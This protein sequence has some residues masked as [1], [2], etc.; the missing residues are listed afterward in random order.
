M[1]DF[2]RAATFLI[3]DLASTICFLVLF[4][5]THNTPVSVAGGAA[6]GLIQIAV[7]LIRSRPVHTMEWL[8][9]FLVAA[10]GTASIL[11][12]DPRFLLFKPSVVYAVVG[13]VMLK[14]GW[15]VRYLPAIVRSV[16][17]DVAVLAGYAFA[18][19]MFVTAAVNAVV[20]ITYPVEIWALV[21][22]VFGIVSK[23]VVFVGGFLAIRLTTGRRLRAMSA[24]AR[25]TLLASS[26]A[27]GL[28]LSPARAA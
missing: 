28:S 19:L 11:T 12:G 1:Q 15:M 27:A 6:V 5:L 25:G 17:S 22:L 21:M 23:V 18:A 14:A 7:Q 3:V 10:G 13:I 26:G 4:L 16:A 24:E 8:S 20:A 9:L 2:L